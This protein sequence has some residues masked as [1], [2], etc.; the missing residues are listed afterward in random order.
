MWHLESVNEAIYLQNYFLFS[1]DRNKQVDK[2]M[3][4]C[5]PS[6]VYSLLMYTAIQTIH[7]SFQSEVNTR[8]QSRPNRPVL[9][10][11]AN[12]FPPYF[13]VRKSLVQLYNFSPNAPTFIQITKSENDF[14]FFSICIFDSILKKITKINFIRKRSYISLISLLP[15]LLYRTIHVQVAIKLN[16]IVFSSRYVPKT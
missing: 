13:L 11:V 9:T 15:Q 10:S 1:K 3:L 2:K 12:H 6:T 5:N 14:T 7:F 16:F 4:L 8:R